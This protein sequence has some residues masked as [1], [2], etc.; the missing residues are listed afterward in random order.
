V[1][2]AHGDQWQPEPE[3][4]GGDDGRLG[5]PAIRLV[6]A[7]PLQL[8]LLGQRGGGPRPAGIDD[9]RIQPDLDRAVRAEPRAAVPDHGAGHGDHP[10]RDE[11][12]GQRRGQPTG[13]DRDTAQPDE[14]PAS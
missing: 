13:D 2:A 14:Q 11:D 10:Q 6:R 1:T 5:Q 12:Q 4:D 8:P 3:R 9:A 7:Q